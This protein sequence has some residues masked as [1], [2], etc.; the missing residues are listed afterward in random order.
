MK[1]LCLGTLLHILS[2]AKISGTKQLSQYGDLLSCY[3]SGQ[4]NYDDSYQGH[5]KS[6]KNNLTNSDNLIS[7]DKEKLIIH[8][9]KKVIPYLKSNTSQK[10]RSSNS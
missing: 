8:M 7:C 10:C 5:L 6:G 2:Q 3:K 1:K 4:D 9:R